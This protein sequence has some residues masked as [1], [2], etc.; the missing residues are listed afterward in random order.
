MAD[1]WGTA[2]TE[3][4]KLLDDVAFES[5]GSNNS[6][7]MIWANRIIKDIHLEIDIRDH[8]T[9]SEIIISG[10][11]YTYNIPDFLPDYCKLSSRFTKFRVDDSYID[12][13]GLD[14]LNAYDP[15][16]DS[17][18][19]GDPT[20]VSIEG[21]YLY[22]S[23]L[24]TCTGTLENYFRLPTDLTATGSTPDLPW[25]Y[26]VTDLIVSGVAGRYG[27]P[28]LNEEAQSNDWKNRYKELMD[29]YRVHVGKSN[30]VQ[31]VE[32]KYY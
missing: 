18:T 4:E 3:L 10:S 7:L 1:T 16:H 23:P 13:V 27:F 19:S 31:T 17:T 32:H 20:Y 5:G 29:K 22:V 21:N 28:W 14:T 24:T 12:M 15:D 8:L 2:Q 25:V 30:S 6:Y 9:S 11:T 26:Y